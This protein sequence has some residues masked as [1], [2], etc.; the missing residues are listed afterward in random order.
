MGSERLWQTALVVEDVSGR[1]WLEF[2][3]PARCRRCRDGR[4]CGAAQWSRLFGSRRAIRLPMPTDCAVE[5]GTPVRVG[6]ATAALLGAAVRVYLLPLLAFVLLLIG[7]G[8]AGLAD[9]L[10][11]AV[12]LVGAFAALWQARRSTPVG[13]RPRIE[14]IGEEGCEALESPG[15]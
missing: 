4:G 6:L 3:D 15:R 1:R 7:A 8:Y 5:P 2:P 11:L 9:G 10:A 14:A 12:G 13:L